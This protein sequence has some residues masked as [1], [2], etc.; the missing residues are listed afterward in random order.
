MYNKTLQ[1]QVQSLE[2]TATPHLVHK[3]TICISHRSFLVGLGEHGSYT[4]NRKRHLP[5]DQFHRTLWHGP[6]LDLFEELVPGS[7]AGFAHVD[8]L[9]SEA[10]GLHFEIILQKAES[11]N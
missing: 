7:V 11:H 3:A 1:K 4:N 10:L 8:V 6:Y 9:G 5:R 2:N